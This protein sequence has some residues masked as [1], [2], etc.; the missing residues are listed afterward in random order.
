M[1]AEAKR[2]FGF[3]AWDRQTIAFKCV[4]CHERL[5]GPVPVKPEDR[6]QKPGW[7]VTYTARVRV[8]VRAPGQGEPIIREGCGAGHG[9]DV[10]QG[11]AHESALKEAETDAMKRALMTI[12]NPFGLALYDK[13]QREVEGAPGPAASGRPP[14]PARSAPAPQVSRQVPPVPARSI[15]PAAGTESTRRT[16]A[17]TNAP[18][19]VPVWRSSRTNDQ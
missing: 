2:I 16:V 6:P 17:A 13:E 19:P 7:G 14:T 5:I 8:T 10:D 18:T 12:G 9:I 11:L 4:T 3:D 15:P 1:I